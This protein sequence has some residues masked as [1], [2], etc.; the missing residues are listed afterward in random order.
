MSMAMLVRTGLVWLLLFPR[1]SRRESMSSLDSCSSFMVFLLLPG[2]ISSQLVSST[3]PSLHQLTL[4]LGQ[5]GTTLLN[6]GPDSWISNFIPLPGTEQLSVS[7]LCPVSVFPG[8]PLAPLRHWVSIQMQN[9]PVQSLLRDSLTS[10]VSYFPRRIFSWE[11]QEEI[12]LSYWWHSLVNIFWSKS[13][14]K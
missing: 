12:V 5:P 13:W 8:S 10:T 3:F 11:T 6:Q 7:R 2:E 4:E 1:H 9:N 14:L